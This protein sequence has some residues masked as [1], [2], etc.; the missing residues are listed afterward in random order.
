MA[1]T[2]EQKLQ[3]LKRLPKKTRDIIGSE[4]L[5]QQLHRIAK[6]HKLNDEKTGVLGDETNYRLLGL[7]NTETFR[8]RLLE[9]LVLPK[10]AVLLIV[11]DVENMVAHV[12]REAP[13]PE[14]DKV[15]NPPSKEQQS[16]SSPRQNTPDAHLRSYND[17][18]REPLE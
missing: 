8:E 6:I 5:S 10:E 7:T 16:P 3:K 12:T 9:N 4:R 1:F 14:P 2:L 11:K 18:Y 13:R 17:P 15:H